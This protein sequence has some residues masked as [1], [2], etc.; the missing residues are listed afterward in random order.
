[1]TAVEVGDDDGALAAIETIAGLSADLDDAG[2]VNALQLAVAWTKPIVEDFED[3]LRAASTA[4]AGFRRQDDPFVAFAELTVGMLEMTLGHDAAARP[5]LLEVDR[6]GGQFDNNWLQ[7]SGR[8]QLATLAVRAGDLDQARSL[9]A[10]SVDAIAG[11]PLSTL[12]LTFT[13]VA[14]AQLAMAD[15]RTAAAANALGAADGLRQRAG[16]RAWPLARQ[17]EAEL[18]ARVTAAL[19][20]DRY[21]EAFAAG[22]ELHAREALALITAPA[23]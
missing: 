18:T 6:L 8:T 17:S 12:T 22:R 9:L 21:R 14:F 13:L 10:T 3:A 5:H 23:G 19:D 7:S 16:L 11:T 1:V 15:G 2:L 4:L 20:P